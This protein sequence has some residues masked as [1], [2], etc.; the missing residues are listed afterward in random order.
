[1]DVIMCMGDSLKPE[2]DLNVF[3]KMPTYVWMRPKSHGYMVIEI[4]TVVCGHKVEDHL[5]QEKND[6]VR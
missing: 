4:T 1:M 2:A 5:A 3:L 6:I